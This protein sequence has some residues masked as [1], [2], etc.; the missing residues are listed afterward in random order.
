MLEFVTMNLERLRCPS[1][2]QPFAV[3]DGKRTEYY[4]R[5]RYE[6]E[7]EEDVVECV[8][9]TCGSCYRFGSENEDIIKEYV[10]YFYCAHCGKEWQSLA[11][12][13]PNT[14]ALPT[15]EFD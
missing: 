9:S 4:L 8:I 5:H 1:C 12:A 15:L 7:I 10:D 13:F 3:A 14:F 11:D 6:A 2:D